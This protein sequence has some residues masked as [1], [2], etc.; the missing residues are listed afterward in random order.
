MT[1]VDK[2]REEGDCKRSTIVFDKL[3]NLSL[4]KIALANDA[5][6]VPKDED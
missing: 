6:A 2:A 3:P 1:S 4:K 5:A